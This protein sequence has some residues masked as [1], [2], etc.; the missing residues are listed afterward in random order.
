MQVH[1]SMET[2]ICKNKPHANDFEAQTAVQKKMDP[3]S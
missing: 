2:Y 1:T 3:I